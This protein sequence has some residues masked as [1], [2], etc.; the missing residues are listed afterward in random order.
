MAS[1]IETERQRV[2]VDDL[3]RCVGEIKQVF[4]I[5]TLSI[6]QFDGLLNFLNRR[7]LFVS[8]PTGSVKS[9]IFQM[10]PLVEMW[11]AGTT[12]GN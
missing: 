1:S 8:L 6:S 7:D 9:L 11:F 12:V 2:S 4:G 3:R 5:N 10:A